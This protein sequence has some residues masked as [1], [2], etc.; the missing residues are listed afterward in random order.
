[1]LELAKIEVSFNYYFCKSILPRISSDYR[2]YL[3]GCTHGS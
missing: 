2:T 3:M 1:L